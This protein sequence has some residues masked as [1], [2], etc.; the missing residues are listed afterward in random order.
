MESYLAGCNRA[1][2]PLAGKAERDE[3]KSAKEAQGMD[4]ELES[5]VSCVAVDVHIDQFLSVSSPHLDKEKQPAKPSEYE[6]ISAD[7]IQSNIT[8][9]SAD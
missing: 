4:P 5:E 2:S 9:L 3:K 7:N 1:V 6:S 8:T